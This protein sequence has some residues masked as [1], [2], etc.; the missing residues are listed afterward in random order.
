MMTI[1]QWPRWGL[2]LA[3][4]WL[5]ASAGPLTAQGDPTLSYG[6]SALGSLSSAQPT[7][8]YLFAGA[9][10]DRITVHVIGLEAGMQPVITLSAP[11][12]SPLAEV[13]GDGPAGLTVTLTRR[14]SG[15]GLYG[16]AVTD[17]AGS[18]GQFALSL[19]G[20][21]QPATPAILPGLPTA[22][23]L[24]PQD[25]PL[26][27]RLPVG[28]TTAPVITIEQTNGAAFSA[29]LYGPDGALVARLAEALDRVTLTLRPGPNLTYTLIITSPDPLATLAL[30][31]WVEVPVT[32]VHPPG[33]P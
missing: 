24:A 25:E 14:L 29:A 16:L 30:N 32:P 31:A 5:A 28:P 1:R 23:T 19:T 4:G 12:G 21:V 20:I 26:V 6:T 13:A 7:A 22:F 8:R 9:A 10:G 17:D 11:D 3:L 33:G 27:F 18:A 2:V 15:N